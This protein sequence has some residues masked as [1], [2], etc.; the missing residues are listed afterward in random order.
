MPAREKPGNPTPGFPTFPPSLEIAARFPHSHTH[1][2]SSYNQSGTQNR[3]RKLLP[4]S[5]DRSVTY[6]PGRTSASPVPP[7]DTPRADVR[8]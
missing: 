4:M 1:D 5:S 3:L 8:T 2:D 6:V 7:R